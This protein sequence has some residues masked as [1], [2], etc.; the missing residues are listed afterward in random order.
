MALAKQA[1][2]NAVK[3]ELKTIKALVVKAAA[4]TFRR[5]GIAFTNEATH[6]DRSLLTDAQLASLKADPS[7]SVTE[8]K[9]TVIVPAD[10]PSTPV[11]TPVAA[12]DPEAK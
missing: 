1:A 4:K 5:I 9:I 3:A 7:L 11:V 10:K 8:A 12:A 2:E 6:L